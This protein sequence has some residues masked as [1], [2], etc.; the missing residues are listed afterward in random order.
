MHIEDYGNW[1]SIRDEKNVISHVRGHHHQDAKTDYAFYTHG[2]IIKGFNNWG[3]L[4][5]SV[6]I[7]PVK[8]V[9]FIEVTFEVGKANE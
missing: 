8:P 1:T 5:T 3:V 9:E 7:Y 4:K 2:R 6:N